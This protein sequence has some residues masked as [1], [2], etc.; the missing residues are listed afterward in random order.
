VGGLGDRRSAPGSA[1][2]RQLP[3]RRKIKG[4][5][6]LR[7]RDQ[8]TV[9]V[10][11]AL[12]PMHTVGRLAFAG[13]VL[14]DATLRGM[15]MFRSH[16]GTVPT[17]ANR[18]LLSEALSPGSDVP[19]RERRAG[20]GVDAPAIPLTD[21]HQP[22]AHGGGTGFWPAVNP[23][24]R[25]WPLTSQVALAFAAGVTRF[26]MPPQSRSWRTL[27]GPF[28]SRGRI[29]LAHPA[30]LGRIFWR[31]WPA[32]K[33]NCVLVC[34]VA[35]STLWVTASAPGSKPPVRLTWLS[36]VSNHALP[37]SS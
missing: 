14:P 5:G 10:R 16:G 8:I 25:V 17:V 20:R 19:C 23:A 1:G 33:H 2:N 12:L 9:G 6:T 29:S 37:H 22:H 32:G 11:R 26:F 7:F 3:A 21:S 36:A 30:R 13:R 18:D 31:G 15:R 27:P 35:T 4:P 28:A 34:A 24:L